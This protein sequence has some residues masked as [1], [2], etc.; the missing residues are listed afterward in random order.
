MIGRHTEVGDVVRIPEA[1]VGY[2]TSDAAL[3][4]SR[5]ENPARRGRSRILAAVDDEYGARRAF[6]DRRTLR[7]L[8][9]LEDLN[10]VEIFACRNVAQRE[11]FADHRQ[12]A[13][14]KRMHIL[15]HLVVQA[16]LEQCCCECGGA[17]FLQLLARFGLKLAHSVA[18]AIFENDSMVRTAGLTAG[19]SRR[20]FRSVVRGSR[21]SH[22]GVS[23]E[24]RSMAPPFPRPSCGAASFSRRWLRAGAR[25]AAL[26]NRSVDD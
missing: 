1:P 7:M 11:R 23:A 13:R 24:Q 8:A 25:L 14:I 15:N 19:S 26:I 16:A 4:Q 22:E 17:D 2:Y 9:I 6:F 10:L 21:K 3:H 20:A 5:H 12:S 18:P